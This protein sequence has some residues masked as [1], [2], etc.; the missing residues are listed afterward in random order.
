[1]SAER[2]PSDAPKRGEVAL[3]KVILRIPS[4]YVRSYVYPGFCKVE[5]RQGTLNYHLSPRSFGSLSYSV[6]QL[7][8]QASSPLC[9]PVP[10]QVAPPTRT[11]DTS[12]QPNQSITSRP[13]PIENTAARGAAGER[14]DPLASVCVPATTEEGMQWLRSLAAV[15]PRKKYATRSSTVVLVD[16]AGRMKVVERNLGGDKSDGTRTK[17]SKNGNAIDDE[18]AAEDAM[19]M[20]NATRNTF[21]FCDV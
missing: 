21:E 17:G 19:H 12:L 11:H 3:N 18:A 14:T 15:L 16:A 1:M 6:V 9:Y 8:N 10:V 13:P 5:L 2:A 4:T 20:R 7:S